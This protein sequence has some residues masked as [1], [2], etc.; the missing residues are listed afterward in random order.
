[1]LRD[2]LRRA[3]AV[4]GFKEFHHRRR[5]GAIRSAVLRLILAEDPEFPAT[6]TILAYAGISEGIDEPP[7][8]GPFRDRGLTAAEKFKQQNWQ[9]WRN[10]ARSGFSI[11]DP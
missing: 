6:A 2:E 8:E 5:K 11:L 10:I 7:K 9:R 4:T 1:M 3:V